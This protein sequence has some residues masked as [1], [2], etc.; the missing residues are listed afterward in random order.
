MDFLSPQVY[1][2]GSWSSTD[3]RLYAHEAAG[4]LVGG[5]DLSQEQQLSYLSTLMSPLLSQI[6]RNLPN[7]KEAA[8]QLSTT[9]QAKAGKLPVNMVLQVSMVARKKANLDITATPSCLYLYVSSL[10]A[11]PALY[12]S[13]QCASA[14]AHF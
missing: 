3:D 7:I 10:R 8:P 11:R 6:E 14:D 5:E 9:D 1:L 13:R 4:L 2:A 12:Q